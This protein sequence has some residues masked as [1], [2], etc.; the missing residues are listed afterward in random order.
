VIA[1]TRFGGHA[2]TIVVPARQALPLPEG[3]SFEEG[4]A[5]PVNYIT[6]YHMLFEVARVRPGDKVLI[7]MAAGGV[8]I[9]ALQLCRTVERIETFGTASSG[10]HEV[11]RKEGC[12]HPI[13]YRTLD[14]ADEIRRL[15]GGKGVHVVL[16][17][18]GGKDWKKGYDLLRPAG[19]LI[20]FG[21]ANMSSGDKRSI[22]NL[23]RQSVQ[24]PIYTPLGLMNDNRGLAGVNIGHLWDE[25][26]I[27]AGEMAA[28]LDLY[29][30]GKIRP[31][32]GE[33]F[34]FDRVGD[35]QRLLSTG[36]N[37]GKVVLVP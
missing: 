15:T 10:K 24:I 29:R 2:D 31:H 35:A 16:D 28:I 21:F 34:P 13:D 6:A 9:A 11:I 25:I 36:K 5:I 14:Y 17:A 4:A 32:V 33:V 20:A 8:G 19:L 37:I 26:D 7:H 18:L 30:Q 1:L 22:V 27:L 12:D 23:I 3:M